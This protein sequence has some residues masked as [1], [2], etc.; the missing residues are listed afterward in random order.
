MPAR[1]SWGRCEEEYRKRMVFHEEQSGPF[2][3]PGEECK[4]EGLDV[5]HFIRPIHEKLMKRGSAS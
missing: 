1:T 3:V 4:D 5:M 2:P